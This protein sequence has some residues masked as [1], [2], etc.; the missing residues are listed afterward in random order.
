MG[1]RW[2][3]RWLLVLAVIGCKV[4]LSLDSAAQVTCESDSDC[5]DD[6]SCGVRGTC[7][8][9][10]AVEDTTPPQIVTTEAAGDGA[11]VVTF[12][13]PVDI[14]SVRLAG[15][16]TITPGLIVEGVSTEAQ[17]VRLFT[18]TQTYEAT[19]T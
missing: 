4:D 8:A 12:S 14:D 7:V 9:S 6:W 2:R 16:Y 5:P 13:E 19:Y 11:V 10:G 1:V 18:S 15:N 3:G 17:S